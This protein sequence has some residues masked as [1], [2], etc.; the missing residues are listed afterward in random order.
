MPMRAEARRKEY[1]VAHGRF[2][3]GQLHAAL[4]DNSDNFL[5]FYGRG[6][7]Y[8][9]KSYA[10]VYIDVLKTISLF[11]SRH[12]HLGDRIGILGAN[13]YA[14]VLADLAAV[15]GGYVSVP[16]PD[17]PFAEQ[18]GSL[19]AQYNLKL[20][21]ADSGYLTCPEMENVIELDNLT[22][23]IVDQPAK[24][25]EVHVPEE[26]QPF[27][28]IFTSGTTGF[29]KGIEVRSKCVAEWISVLI[30]RFDFEL[31]DKVLDFLPLSISN[32]RL[33]VYAAI[34]LP[35]NLT[36]TVPDQLMRVLQAAQPTILQGVPYL[37]ETVYGNVMR[38]IQTSR[39]RQTAYSVYHA[40]KPMLPLG[41]R[42]RLQTRIFGQALQ[43]W[44][45]R[46]RLLVTGSAAISPKVLSLFD[47][48][49]L[50]I[51]E[52][53]G[54]NEVGL[55]SINSPGQNR[56]GSVG[57]PFP[58]KQIKI[59]DQGE[60]L[61]RSDYSW[62]SSYLNET[63]ERSAETF[64]SD[65]YIS[66]GDLGY[67]DNE[68]YLHII[69]RIKEVIALTTGEKIHPNQVEAAL[70]MSASVNQVAA[71]G[72][73][74]PFI[75]CVVVPAAASTT[76]DHIEASIAAANKELPPALHIGGYVIAKEA[77]STENGLMNATLKI[78]RSRIHEVYRQEIT[79]IYK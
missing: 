4:R 17:R 47:D 16:F 27:M 51:Y 54:I 45:G 1:E 40:L 23:S 78:N 33:F 39:L 69:G 55:V 25:Q 66:T 34:L 79:S 13:S 76:V 49:G 43:F 19:Q 70:K 57:R 60:I 41:L 62:G 31:D 22:E 63:V 46:M 73:G 67:V 75:S 32:A 61:I 6:S 74:R 12:L 29:P 11:R 68:G 38:A 48:M 21:L 26:E 30:D 42:A 15:M 77:F 7:M 56:R 18:V 8:I 72:D 50:I 52:S 9:K 28:I 71:F 35:F 37:F 14:Y 44:G 58:T 64:K 5:E 36:V 20:L 59:D 10:D 3:L 24:Q 2:G 65:G 53:Y